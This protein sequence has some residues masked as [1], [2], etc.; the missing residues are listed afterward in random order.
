MKEISVENIT[1]RVMKKRIKNMYLRIDK[2]GQPTVSAPL[3]LP[4][5][6]I[7]KFVF[8]R[9]NWLKDAIV[10]VEKKQ[11]V[12]PKY[13]D[14]DICK[15]FGKDCILRIDENRKDGCFFSGDEIVLRVGQNSTVEIRKK[16]LARFY[17]E[18]MEQVLPDMAKICQEKSG[19]YAKEWRIRD[20]TTR[21]GSCNTR[22]KRIWISLWLAE[23]PVESIIGVIYH[24]LVHLKV[25]GHGKDFYALL[26]KIY[27]EYKK[28]EKLLKDR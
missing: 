9:V 12:E 16:A 1:V 11:L 20:M 26:E 13:E 28:H 10:R 8:S 5:S 18:S 27:P 17:R 24:E 2:K 19:L 3:F 14:G 6:E 25:K 22:E 4:D 21:W 15:L 23:K 7:E